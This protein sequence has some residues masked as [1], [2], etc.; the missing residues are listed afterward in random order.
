MS[1]RYQESVKRNENDRLKIEELKEQ[2]LESKKEKEKADMSWK[3][4]RKALLSVRDDQRKEEEEWQEIFL[5]REN[6]RL[7]FKARIDY[8]LTRVR[9]PQ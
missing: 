6:E 5:S 8:L 3:L 1:F 4:T 7:E 9:L 2:I